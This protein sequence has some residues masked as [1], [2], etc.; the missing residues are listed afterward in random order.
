[1][2]YLKR[3]LDDSREIAHRLMPKAIQDFGLV[4][5]VEGMIEELNRNDEINIQFNTNMYGRR[6]KLSVANNLFKIIQEALN[7]ILKHAKANVVTIQY[8]LVDNVLHLSIED[9]GIGFDK[10]LFKT[11]D[12]SG[13]GL[14][15]MRSRATAL[16]AEFFIDSYPNHGT[17]I[18][19]EL[20]F[21]KDIEY[22]PEQEL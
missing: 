13:F 15:S 8:M 16:S 1:M 6:V 18:M 2:E 19:I 9:D 20:P 22:L 10:K 3:S 14:A 4:P 21:T 12:L 17:T 11:N 5:V 7:N